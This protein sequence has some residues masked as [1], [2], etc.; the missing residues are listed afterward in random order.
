MKHGVGPIRARGTD[1]VACGLVNGRLYDVQVLA[2]EQ[3][4]LSCVRV[5]PADVDDGRWVAEPLER[6]I[7][8]RD[9]AP[10]ALAGDER[11]GFL[12]TDM[13]R[14]VCNLGAAETQHQEDVVGAEPSLPG[15]ERGVAVELDPG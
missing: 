12:D 15:D 1:A 6:A 10:D 5:Q 9:D 7:G 13:Q 8:G 2:A 3:A 14:A 4:V 11:D